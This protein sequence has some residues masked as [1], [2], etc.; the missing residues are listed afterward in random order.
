MYS[1]ILHTGGAALGDISTK[2]NSCSL[3]ISKAL[4]ME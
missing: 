2:S 1:I 4:L 3:A